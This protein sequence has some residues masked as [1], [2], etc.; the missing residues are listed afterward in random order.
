[1][2][3]R[4]GFWLDAITSSFDE[5]SSSTNC[6]CVTWH[7]LCFKLPHA[8]YLTLTCDVLQISHQ[9]WLDNPVHR[10]Q[11]L[12]CTI[13]RLWVQIPEPC[14]RLLTLLLEKG[15]FPLATN[16]L[17]CP[18]IMAAS[19]RLHFPEY[20]YT[21]SSNV[22]FHTFSQLRCVCNRLSLI[23]TLT[24]AQAYQA[25]FLHVYSPGVDLISGI[26][27]FIL[28]ALSSVLSFRLLKKK[29]KKKTGCASSSCIM[30]HPLHSTAIFVLFFFSIFHHSPGNSLESTQEYL[31]ME[32]YFILWLNNHK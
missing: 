10:L 16:C 5:L 11:L 9:L 32:Y 22:Q 3:N 17:L 18:T 1:M 14:V 29:R 15:S 23:H 7:L 28:L 4:Y 8:T 27:L 12:S 2:Q 24:W 30:W 25:L 21:Q 13:R 19:T 31:I 6:V 20:T 26:A